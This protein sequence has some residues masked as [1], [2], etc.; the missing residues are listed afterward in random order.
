MTPQPPVGIPARPGSRA[1]RLSLAVGTTLSVVC[2]GVALALAFAGRPEGGGPMADLGAVIASAAAL[3]SWGWAT[4][5]TYAVIASP[6]AAI[7]TTALEHARVHDR[8]TAWTAAAVLGI[9]GAS[10]AISLLGR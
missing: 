3:E 1:T 5:G 9:L 6:V 7:A 8:R 2:F 10:L 4:L